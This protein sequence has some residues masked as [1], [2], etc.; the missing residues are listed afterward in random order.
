MNNL[1][2]LFLCFFPKV[3]KPYSSIKEKKMHKPQYLQINN[4]K[5]K[6]HPNAVHYEQRLKDDHK[7]FT[8][9]IGVTNTNIAH[10]IEMTI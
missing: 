9:G 7:N 4:N 5:Q 1:H 6:T 2:L 10:N 3:S 8:G